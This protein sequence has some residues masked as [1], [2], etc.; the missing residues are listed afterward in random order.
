MAAVNGEC[1]VTGTI[2]VW[3]SRN[4][5][6]VDARDITGLNEGLN[7]EYWESDGKN[8]WTEFDGNGYSYWEEYHRDINS[9]YLKDKNG[10]DWNT[11]Y[12]DLFVAKVML[13]D[14]R[15]EVGKECFSLGSIT[16]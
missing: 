14:S 1:K 15:L 2:S 12:L 10:R 13:C 11:A 7:G 9:I 5:F 6:G 16:D 8:Q 3:Y 4:R